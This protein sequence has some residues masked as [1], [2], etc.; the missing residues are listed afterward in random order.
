MLTGSASHAPNHGMYVMLRDGR[1]VAFGR[2]GDF[3][4]NPKK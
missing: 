4:V 1:V 2:H 3:G